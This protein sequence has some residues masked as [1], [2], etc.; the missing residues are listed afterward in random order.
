MAIRLSGSG[1]RYNPSRVG[2]VGRKSY[3]EL[4]NSYLPHPLKSP[5]PSKERGK[6]ILKRGV[7]PS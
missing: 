6:V 5:S 1:R 4:F 2:R 7:S 3:E